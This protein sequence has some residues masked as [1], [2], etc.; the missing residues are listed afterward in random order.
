ML[1]AP[2]F[3]HSKYYKEYR[4]FSGKKSDDGKNSPCC[5]TLDI[6]YGPLL[7][8]STSD[9]DRDF[10][11]WGEDSL[12]S[13]I[14]RKIYKEFGYILLDHN[15]FKHDGFCMRVYS[16]PPRMGI[17]PMQT[18][19]HKHDIIPREIMADVQAKYDEVHAEYE[20]ASNADLSN[21][22]RVRFVHKAPGAPSKPLF[23]H[24]SKAAPSTP[25]RVR[26]V[27]KA[28]DAPS[29]PPFEHVEVAVAAPAPAPP[30][31]GQMMP[32]PAMAHI[33]PSPAMG[34]IMPVGFVQTAYG[35]MLALIMQPR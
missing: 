30:A 10:N 25:V 35:P 26:S 32:S 16:R 15:D 17:M 24:A 31:M 1:Y 20:K 21:P 6:L 12:F 19:T 22:V 13:E 7:Q 28:P 34:Q 9:A 11:A 3:I 14:Q 5:T 2:V 8:G 18:E 33:M 27:H 4:W 29:K 23:E